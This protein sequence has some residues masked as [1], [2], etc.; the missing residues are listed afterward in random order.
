VGVHAWPGTP[1]CNLPRSILP[2]LVLTVSDIHDNT[3][4]DDENNRT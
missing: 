4:I 1:W 2:V 3:L